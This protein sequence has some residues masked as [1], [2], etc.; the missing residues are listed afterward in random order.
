MFL[1]FGYPK[2]NISSTYKYPG[3]YGQTCDE[4]S[5][6]YNQSILKRYSKYNL[7]SIPDF[8]E[9]SEKYLV[10]SLLVYNEI[11]VYIRTELQ[12]S[13][14]PLKCAYLLQKSI[15]ITFWIN[16]FLKNFHWTRYQYFTFSIILNMYLQNNSVKVTLLKLIFLVAFIQNCIP[17]THTHIHR[18]LSLLSWFNLNARDSDQR[19]CC[20][21]FNIWNSLFCVSYSV[22]CRHFFI[23]IFI[24]NI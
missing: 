4:P 20:S 15:F 21:G 23:W 11:F 9:L 5:Y 18:M 6:G 24:E 1:G 12:I 17:Y 3:S 10:T 22:R 16:L 19:E 7:K 8:L 13:L 2:N 14:I